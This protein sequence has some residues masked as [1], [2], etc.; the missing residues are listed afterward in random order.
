MQWILVFLCPAVQEST[1]SVG[2]ID[3]LD[4]DF[5][6]LFQREKEEERKKYVDGRQRRQGRQ[7]R[8]RDRL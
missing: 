2:G 5:Y 7:S 1:R 4:G 6:F 3:G 8:R